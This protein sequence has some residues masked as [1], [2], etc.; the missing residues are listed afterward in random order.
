MGATTCGAEDGELSL[1]SQL[2]RISSAGWVNGDT[3]KHTWLAW[4]ANC[5]VG[6]AGQAVAALPKWAQV[7]YHEHARARGL[8]AARPLNEYVALGGR[9]RDPAAAYAGGGW[10]RNLRCVAPLL[11]ARF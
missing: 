9:L 7:P 8:S 1:M 6:S 5:T 2:P 4:D 10:P 11:P 3:A